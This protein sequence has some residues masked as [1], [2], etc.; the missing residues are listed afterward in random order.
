MKVDL[1]NEECTLLIQLLN[2]NVDKLYHIN[3]TTGEI[4]KILPNNSDLNTPVV[5]DLWNKLKRMS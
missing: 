5:W 4:T 2:Y 1:T 3:S